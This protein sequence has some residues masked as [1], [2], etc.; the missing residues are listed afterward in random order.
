[1]PEF[2][3]TIGPRAVVPVDWGAAV[4]CCQFGQGSEPSVQA[5]A[6]EARAAAT[7]A[8]MMARVSPRNASI[9]PA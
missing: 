8:S 3:A 4:S 6:T 5:Q 9:V 2:L 7:W 1:M